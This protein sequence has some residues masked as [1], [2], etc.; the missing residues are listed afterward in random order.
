[1]H[2]FFLWDQLMPLNLNEG[3]ILTAVCMV[4][5][6]N[7]LPDYIH[8]QQHKIS[9]FATSTLSQGKPLRH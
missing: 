2:S 4:R 7:P 3:P 1:M 8:R 9:H 5:R 6:A